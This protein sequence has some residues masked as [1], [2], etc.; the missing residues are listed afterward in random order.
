MDDQN[1]HLQYQKFFTFAPLTLWEQ[2]FSEIQVFFEDL[3]MQGVEDL[4][5]YLDDHPDQ[6]MACIKRIRHGAVNEQT[7]KMYGA[8]TREELLANLDQIFGKEMRLHFRD[9]LLALWAGQRS[10]S[11]EG[12]NHT[13]EGRPLDVLLSWRILPG[14]EQT[15]QSVLVAIED[16][17]ARK[18]A[19]QE[20]EAS[21]NRL[22]G[23]FENSPISLWEEDYSQIQEYFNHLRSSGVQDLKIYLDEHPAEVEHCMSM[24]RVLDVNQKTLEMFAAP[25]KEI[26]IQNLQAIFRDE[27]RAHFKQELIDLWN[28]RLAYEIDGVNYRLDGNPIYIRLNLSVFPGYE[29]SF[30]RVLVAIQDITARRKA[31]EYLRYLGTHDVLTGLYNRAYYEEELKRLSGSRQYP[32]SIL[33]ADIDGLKQINDHLG[34]SVG[35]KII[36][37]AGEVLKSAFRSEDVV[38]R[39][40][41]DEFAVIM[42]KT[43]AHVAREASSRI[44][45]LIRLNNQY[46]GDPNL[47]MSIGVST[48]TANEDL[49]A[50]MRAADDQMY[51]QKR[52]RRP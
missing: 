48:A 21:E 28:G 13:L 15:W 51:R 29:Q 19:E 47:Q 50:T 30:R 46:Y 11:G 38:A 17:S 25:S 35:D 2:D 33:L 16:I 39:I 4:E 26:L 36:K 42:P 5:K 45:A 1:V 40:G 44:D 24:I 18:Q 3:R 52:G 31:E 34:H 10:W 8:A 7:L 49:Y 32:I 37:R 22:R 43:D 9:E 27:M 14:S 23:L 12:I 41:G 6:V 20:L